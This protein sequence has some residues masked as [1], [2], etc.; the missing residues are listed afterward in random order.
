MEKYIVVKEKF[1]HPDIGDYESY[2]IMSRDHCLLK[3]PDISVDYE[4]VSSLARLMNEHDLEEIHMLDVVY[5]A[6]G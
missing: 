5:D 2:G 4:L 3:I 6:I 1:T